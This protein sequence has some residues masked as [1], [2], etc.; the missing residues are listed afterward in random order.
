MLVRR[1]S[2]GVSHGAAVAATVLQ[3]R[4]SSVWPVITVAKGD[5]RSYKTFHQVGISLKPWRRRG[6]RS[7]LLPL[8]SNRTCSSGAALHDGNHVLASPS[9]SKVQ[10]SIIARARCDR[11]P[12]VPD[13]IIIKLEGIMIGTRKKVRLHGVHRRALAMASTP[14]ID[15]VLYSISTSMAA[16]APS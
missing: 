2:V 11:C 9:R 5:R 14:A 15:I 4:W 7:S 8:C 12:T 13:H 3:G 16:C 6:D 10:A 1:S